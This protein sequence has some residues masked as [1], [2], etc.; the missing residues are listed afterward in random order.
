MPWR[1][2]AILRALRR[3][4]QKVAPTFTETYQNDV[5][6][7]HPETARLLMQLFRRKFEP[8]GADHLAGAAGADHFAGRA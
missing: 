6:A 3:Y 5:L 8:D 2:V 7:S 1:D 4:R